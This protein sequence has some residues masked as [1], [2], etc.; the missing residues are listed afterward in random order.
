MLVRCVG[1]F[2]EYEE[3]YSS[4]PDCGYVP[5]S[6]AAELY[7]LTPG[8]LLSKRYTV[9]QVLG[10][11]GF[12]II[13]KAWDNTE[14]ALVAIKEYYPSGLVNRIPGNPEVKLS[15]ESRRDEFTE[16]KNRFSAEAAHTARFAQHPNI[17]TVL[18]QFEENNSIYYV[19]EFLHGKTLGQ[20]L[21]DN[22]EMSI[23]QG[24][25]VISQVM[26]AVKTVHKAG[27]LHRDIGPDNIIIPSEYPEGAVKLIDF[28]AARFSPSDKE[29]LIT[30]IMKPGYSPPEQYEPGGDQSE[31]MDIYALGATLYIM[32]TNMKP[33]ESTNRKTT[34]ELPPPNALNE[35]IPNY[36]SDAILKAMAV[37]PRM[38]FSTVSDFE[39]VLSKRVT[40]LSPDAEVKKRK[41]G[42][43]RFLSVVL[44][45][46]FLGLTVLAV[47]F[48]QEIDRTTLPPANIQMWYK[49]SGDEAADQAKEIAMASIVERFEEIYPK[50]SVSL[51]GYVG[52]EYNEKL[53]SAA[54]RGNQPILFES[55]GVAED[56][57][58]ETV[59]LSDVITRTQAS[60][61]YFLGRYMRYFPDKH[62][63]PLGFNVLALYI[64]PL[65]CHY[66]ENG[67]SDI[68]KLLAAMPLD[69]S[70]Q[71][72]SVSETKR[73][74]YSDVFGGS[75]TL[76][77]EEKFFLSETGA[78]FSSTSEFYQVR[79]KMPAQYKVLY[80]DREAVPAEF[81][82]LWSILSCGSAERKTAKRL[83]Q[84]M[85]TEEP[86][87][88][89][90]IRSQSGALPV[91][92][93]VMNIYNQQVYTEYSMFFENTS[94]YTF[95][96]P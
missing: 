75:V 61:C 8:T 63:I 83:L 50:I 18:D 53:E 46:V 82:N 78:Y 71:G 32:L 24:L 13:Y 58:K 62:Q 37:E 70:L 3:G 66:E 60:E 44:A 65:L 6:P 47:E 90:H 43:R 45:V 74:Y 86:Q 73:D 11:G 84:F 7:F 22:G 4:C 55:T 15:G 9:G 69:I 29:Y 41:K 81:C 16:G 2:R 92:K 48:W 20:Y 40:V 59:D 36:I 56:V 57:L 30:R 12:G 93:E 35:D 87:D 72:L 1:C 89:L 28:G 25:Q 79:M 23:H 34:D 91:N 49:L 42:R 68:S 19:M 5:G 14:N 26:E 67:V 51:N 17:V 39:N 33:E 95:Y 80:I 54:Q 31:R 10:S 76:A 21:E 96:Q 77:E 85:L 27:I 52:E 88:I 94:Q 64:N 38:R